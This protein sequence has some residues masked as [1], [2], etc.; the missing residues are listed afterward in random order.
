[1]GSWSVKC[2]VSSLPITSGD[3]VVLLL[4]A[5]F[6][7]P[8]AS[9][10][11]GFRWQGHFFNLL[12][13]PIYGKYNDYGWIEDTDEISFP[14]ATEVLKLTYGA[15]GDNRNEHDK[16]LDYSNTVRVP[17][18]MMKLDEEVH[19][20]DLKTQFEKMLH[21]DYDYTFVHRKIWDNLVA[22]AKDNFASELDVGQATQYNKKTPEPEQL[23]AMAILKKHGC[24]QGP[25]DFGGTHKQMFD[26]GIEIF[27]TDYIKRDKTLE[28][29]RARGI[30]PDKLS[31]LVTIYNTRIENRKSTDLPPLKFD[32][33]DDLKLYEEIVEAMNDTAMD[34]LMAR[35]GDNSSTPVARKFAGFFDHVVKNRKSFSASGANTEYVDSL[36]N[37]IEASP[38]NRQRFFETNLFH[39]ALISGGIVI[40]GQEDLASEEQCGGSLWAHAAVWNAVGEILTTEAG[41][42]VESVD[43][44]DI[45]DDGYEALVTKLEDRDF[46]VEWLIERGKNETYGQYDPKPKSKK[47]A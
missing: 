47:K 9:D 36:I 8:K 25:Y 23:A 2:A 31:K 7:G 16:G 11:G 5:T 17:A 14:L 38:E 32:E 20:H 3:D 12:A 15:M 22:A 13:T 35:H 46:A 1:M 41:N 39:I 24:V 18:E 40:R 6:S 44:G 21:P 26:A 10:T 34:R 37:L 43:L 4:G 42:K 19:W 29:F 27:K 33:E 30:S 45:D 28:P